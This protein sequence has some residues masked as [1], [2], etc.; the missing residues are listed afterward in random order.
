MYNVW[1]I[2]KREYLERIRTKSFL[3]FTIIF[4]LLMGGGIV[5]ESMTAA[6]AKTASD[7]AVVAHDEELAIDQ[8]IDLRASKARQDQLEVEVHLGELLELIP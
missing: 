1:L 7:I 4:P 2:A 3:F 6:H 5:V 8:V